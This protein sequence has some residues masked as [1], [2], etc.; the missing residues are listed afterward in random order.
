MKDKLTLI[1]FLSLLIML[2]LKAQDIQL[3]TEP[4]ENRIDNIVVY[5]KVN[6]DNPPSSIALKINNDIYT[7]SVNDTGLF[8]QPY[9]LNEGANKVFVALNES[10]LTDPEDSQTLK[11]IDYKLPYLSINGTISGN[12]ISLNANGS[13]QL[14]YS[15]EGD[16]RNP[17]NVSFSS[18][19]EQTITATIPALAGEYFIFCTATDDEGR[20][21]KAGRLITQTGTEI[22]INSPTEHANWVD[23]IMMYEYQIFR[24]NYEDLPFERMS[25]KFA[26]IKQLGANS[27]WHTPPVFGGGGG[28]V[29]NDYYLID[30]EYG[31]NE[32]YKLFVEKAH[33]AGLKVIFDLAVGH[34]NKNHYFLNNAYAL[35]GDSPYKDY[36]YWEGEPGNSQVAYSPDN[37]PH[38]V[39]TNVG[40]PEFKEYLLRVLEYWV[41]EYNID[42]YRYDC[43]QEIFNRDDYFMQEAQERLRNIKPDIALF[44]EGSYHENSDYLTVAD[45]CYDWMLHGWGNQ[46][47]FKGIFD[48]NITVDQFH[49]NFMQDFA[50]S[51]LPLRYANVGYFEP[52]YLTY[53]K[54]RE[55][56][57]HIIAF[58]GF[59]SALIYAG[60]E[61]GSPA[62][63]IDWEADLS[64][65][66]FMRKVIKAKQK[67]LGSYPEL[68]LLT[69]TTPEQVY[70]YLSKNG[71]NR[72]VVISNLSPNAVNTIVNL[73]IEEINMLNEFYFTDLINDIETTLTQSE[74]ATVDV[75]LNAWESKMY[76]IGENP[77][78]FNKE[79][80]SIVIENE[81]LFIDTHQGWI[82]LNYSVLPSDALDKRVEWSVNDTVLASITV[83]GRLSASGLI[84]GNVIVTATTLDN[85]G[86][87][88]S[89]EVPISNQ[90]QYHNCIQNPNFNEI[91]TFW[92]L[93][94]YSGIV[95]FSNDNGHANFNIEESG[96]NEWDIA[97]AQPFILLEPNTEYILNFDLKSSLN[98]NIRCQL[99]T[100]YEPYSTQIWAD[101]EAN[102]E[103]E[104]KTYSFT[105]PSEIGVFNL[106]F[107]MADNIGE[108]SFDN[109]VLK[110]NDESDLVNV[111]FKVDM[112]YEIVATSG[113]FL[114]GSFNN[115]NS[116]EPLEANESVYSKTFEFT[117]NEIVEYKFLNG[118]QWEENLPDDC[119]NGDYGNRFLT[120]PDADTVLTAVCF[121][122]CYLCDP[123]GLIFNNLENVIIFPNPTGDFISISGIPSENNIKLLLYDM[124]GRLVL[125]KKIDSSSAD[126]IDI[127]NYPSGIYNLL[128]IGDKWIKQEKV[129]IM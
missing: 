37:G 41:R 44:I 81:D 20:T 51:T 76:W 54:E 63:P 47:G 102:I 106:N 25:E 69:N 83:D 49:N 22:S 68:T 19:S 39:Y 127:S 90:Q 12:S 82:M 70:S 26:H 30:P 93:T 24:H 58:T 80:E 86:V 113:V 46:N 56:T 23:S 42:G 9:S 124:N 14:T 108:I 96:V 119:S 31:T 28:Y 89:F 43:G 11:F 107:M 92:N 109:F 94:R 18:T 65:Y 84:N 129:T 110:K 53:D 100:M 121:N 114:N 123:E 74:L 72:I 78:D 17:A 103:W 116:T 79:V 21:F 71:E 61:T 73:D 120:I 40:N 48:Q 13:S 101:C 122:S 35:K 15:W 7:V 3:L 128:L 77:I 99:C 32:D 55:K 66:P 1:T 38:C 34:T 112:L 52:L 8:M 5:G 104:N 98:Q 16:P 111:T 125:S 59:G 36:Y 62:G 118:S 97:L 27:V 33:N 50:D 95:E 126:K 67:L 2:N 6:G 117:Q 64:M 29:V 60:T 87:S 85:S 105:T 45:I 57:A 75:S 88:N 4:L 115:W 10:S 91:F